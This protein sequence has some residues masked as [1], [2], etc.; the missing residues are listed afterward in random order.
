MDEP[1]VYAVSVLAYSKL[2][3]FRKVGQARVNG[4]R[5]LGDLHCAA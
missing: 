4:Q 1:G 5:Q 3:A 2:A